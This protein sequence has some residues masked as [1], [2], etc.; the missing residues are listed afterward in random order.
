LVDLL[1]ARRNQIFAIVTAPLLWTTQFSLAIEAWRR[2]FGPAIDRW[3]AAVGELE[4]LG[5]LATYAFENPEL[6][7]P[8]VL[9]DGP[10][11]RLMGGRE[12][13]RSYV[14]SSRAAASGSPPPTTSP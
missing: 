10:A 8:T 3:L 13:R 12:R 4:A 14:G 2:A 7:F 11:P 1:D 6:P 9:D 5:S